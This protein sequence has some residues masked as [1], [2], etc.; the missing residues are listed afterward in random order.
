[1]DT[2]ERLQFIL[3]VFLLAMTYFCP[4]QSVRRIYTSSLFS[5]SRVSSST[6]RTFSTIRFAIP[7]RVTA[8]PSTS[9]DASLS[10]SSSKKKNNTD[11]KERNR[12]KKESD[13]S[14]I[15]KKA[16]VN[17]QSKMISKQILPPPLGSLDSTGSE[18]VN[19]KEALNM[20]EEGA[21]GDEEEEEDQVT[22]RVTQKKV[23]I[24]VEKCRQDVKKILK[25]VGIPD[26]QVFVWFCSDNKI[27]DLNE[28]WRDI[29]KST[30]VLSFPANDFSSPEI[31]SE[32]SFNQLGDIVISPSYVLRSI[33]RD[34]R[35]SHLRRHNKS[36]EENREHEEE[37]EEEDAG[38]N[39]VMRD[40]FNLDDRITLLLI[41]SILHLLGYD[42]ETEGDWEKMTN[43]ENEV[44]EKL[45][46]LKG[47]QKGQ[48]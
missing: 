18:A 28:E 43:R 39:L 7:K 27:R 15:S 17:L 41:H 46:I 3:F 22:I 30:D 6:V 14:A 24:N 29:R 33:A 38:V 37:E 8:E 10:S 2:S 48:K 1:M 11:S 32:E 4:V 12:T 25:A 5:S 35:D 36:E 40:T 45:G 16:I 47:F 13:A 19:L 44:M 21:E 20:K 23:P 34:Q 26:F 9:I 31:F 42:H